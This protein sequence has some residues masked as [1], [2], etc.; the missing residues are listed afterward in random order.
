VVD[1]ETDAEVEAEADAEVELEL[2]GGGTATLLETAP[3]AGTR[4]VMLPLVAAARVLKAARVFLLCW[5]MLIPPT[6]PALQ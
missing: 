6:I 2:L 1:F 5:L 3:P 4:S